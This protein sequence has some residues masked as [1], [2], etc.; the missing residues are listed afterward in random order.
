MTKRLLGVVS[1]FLVA[2]ASQAAAPVTDT[3]TN[4]FLDARGNPVKVAVR[5]FPLSTPYIL[6]GDSM[7]GSRA[8]DVPAAA[9]GTWSTVLLSGLYKFDY[10]SYSTATT[11]L[12][13]ATG[14]TINANDTQTNLT[15]FLVGSAV[16]GTVDDLTVLGQ[17]TNSGSLTVVSNI[18]AAV[19]TGAL[20]GTNISD[21][22]ITSNKLAFAIGAGGGSTN[23]VDSGTNVGFQ[24]GATF[25]GPIVAPSVRNAAGT[26]YFTNDVNGFGLDAAPVNGRVLTIGGS[27]SAAQFR[28]TG[29]GG[30]FFYRAKINGLSGYTSGD[31]LF[32]VTP[33]TGQ[34]VPAFQANST[35]GTEGLTVQPNGRV[36]IGTNGINVASGGTFSGNGAGLTNLVLTGPTNTAPVDTATVKAWANFTNSAGDLFKYPLYQ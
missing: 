7:V 15:S 20:D 8:V 13:T 27:V 25:G 33:A 6:T 31:P 28:D 30:N 24:G 22:T 35:N 5:I 36:D 10:G 14:A 23:T 9:D 12:I 26:H 3:V 17:Q 18:M 21:G 1:V 16:D 11:N 2:V 32:Y 29:S 4:L 19:L 34:T